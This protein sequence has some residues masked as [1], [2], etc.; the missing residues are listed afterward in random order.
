MKWSLCQRFKDGKL[1]TPALLG[2]DRP[3]DVTGRYIKYA[4]LSVNKR[5]AKIVQFIY[6]AYLSGWS[7]EDIASFLTKI[8]C[9]TKTG[10]TEWNSTS[11]GYILTNERYCGNVLT[12]KTFTADLYE[13]K[14]K[15]NNQDRDQ[16]LYK[17]QHE[18][19]ISIEK[20]EEVQIL[21]QNR[22]HAL[23]GT[24]PSM[25]VIGA[26]I[27]KGFIPINHHWVNDDPGI[28]YDISNSIE[29]SKSLR[30]IS[31]QQFSCF[32]LGGY[33]VVRNQFTQTRYEGPALTISESSI[34]FN[35]F[36]IKKFFDVGF[37][38]LLLHPTER[39][40]AIRPCSETSN[41]SIRW[42]LNS[43]SAI[44]S[45][46][47][48]CRHFGA[49]LFSIMNWSPDYVYRL[50]GIWA[51]RQDEQIIVFNLGNAVPTMRISDESTKRIE[52][53]PEEWYDNFGD[54]FYEHS[55]ENMQ[56]TISSK[57]WESQVQSK[58]VSNFDYYHIPSAED[59]QKSIIDL[60]EG[61]LDEAN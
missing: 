23:K 42:R 24:L 11:I 45:K 18:A 43:D 20:F 55:V 44:S 16:Y 3:K 12:W 6:D 47:L 32:D 60:K 61:F 37:V 53:C 7:Q 10:G 50:R 51:K 36:C 39:K 35:L 57:D 56:F 41:H 58:P 1:L 40:I 38:Q 26:G 14:H 4:P 34:S 22:K 15:K 19:I 48:S 5:E 2:Y 27:F 54:E 59:F 46:K 30:K 25:Q 52:L 49:A 28:Y 33:Q 17:G 29:K 31:K 21:I 8:R 9:P 13:H